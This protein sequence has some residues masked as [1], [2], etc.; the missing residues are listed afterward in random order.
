MIK[1]VSTKPN[2][3][4]LVGMGLSEENVKRL[5]E[6]KPISFNLDELGFEGLEGL[7]F[8]GETEESI[9]ADLRAKGLVP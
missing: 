1:F 7:I 2:G 5:K 9:V 6:G 4:K 3:T 8:Y